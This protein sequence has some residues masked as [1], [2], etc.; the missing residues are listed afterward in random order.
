LLRLDLDL[1]HRQPQTKMLGSGL[2]QSY[3]LQ[4]MIP[5]VLLKLEP[6]Y[7]VQRHRGIVSM[8]VKSRGRCQ[9]LALHQQRH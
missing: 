4:V 3:P 1:N 6:G 5:E 7:P 2:L 8:A 9:L